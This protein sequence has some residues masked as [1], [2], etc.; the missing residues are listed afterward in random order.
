MENERLE[1]V[2][3][4]LRKAA[5]SEDRR[6]MVVRDCKPAIVSIKQLFVYQP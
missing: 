5:V 6:D 3:E 4:R 1:E 2:T